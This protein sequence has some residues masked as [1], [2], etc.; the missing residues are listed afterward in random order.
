MEPRDQ[1]YDEQSSE[2]I[3]PFGHEWLLGSHIEDVSPEEMQRRF[4]EMFKQGASENNDSA[5]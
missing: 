1:F 4:D 2:V 5:S 3:G